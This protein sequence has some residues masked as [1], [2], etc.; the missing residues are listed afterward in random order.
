MKLISAALC[1]VLVAVGWG[2][3]PEPAM[4]A[5]EKC[6][7]RIPTIVGDPANNVINGTPGDDVISGRGGND[8]IDGKGGDDVICGGIGHDVLK[9][10]S[11]KDILAGEEGN[12]LLN[13]GPD[14]DTLIGNE[15]TD[16]ATFAGAPQAVTVKLGPG[17]AFGQ[18]ADT[19]SGIENVIG[20]AH[21]DS[22]YGSAVANRLEGRGGND[23][24][25]GN[26]GRDELIGGDGGD[27]LD[28][29]V[30]DDILEGNA[31]WDLHDGKSGADQCLTAELRVRC[32][33]GIRT[34]GGGIWLVTE[35][36]PAGYYR[37]TTSSSGCYWA[38]LSGFIGELDDI[39]SNEFTF[40]RDIVEVTGSEKGLESS[41]CGTWTNDLDPRKAPGAK[42]GGGAYLVNYEVKPG[43]WRNSNS[44]D[45][46]Y[47]ERTT[48]FTN[49]L[50]QITANNFAYNVQT[51]RV[52]PSDFGFTS[53]GCGT[54]TRIAN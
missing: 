14:G 5:P 2:V 16:T 27:V 3:I 53:S 8:V 40:D 36:V 41:S 30:G 11:G 22:I 46:C 26:K 17:T 51:V 29:G 50:V 25:V 32:E 15:L 18:G 21:G 44:S 13:G 12:D 45:G 49:G 42:M 7:G 23:D 34:F 33:S 38:R 20:S 28:G 39:I 24:I 1:A 10:G 52:Y 48:G 47:W 4:A 54:W 35:E 37:N 43:L 9:G 31:G 6:R 19:L